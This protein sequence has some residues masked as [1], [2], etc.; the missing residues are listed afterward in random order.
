MSIEELYDL[1]EDFYG[2]KVK[3]RFYNSKTD[4]VACILYDSFWLNCGLDNQY[5]LFEAGIVIGNGAGVITEFFGKN[6]SLNSDVNSIKNSLQIIDEYC[7]LR[8][9][10]KFLDVYDR[11]YSDKE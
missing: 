11:I 3:M 7:R 8:L 10:D 6:C 1:I 4:E 2:Y 5:G 9:P